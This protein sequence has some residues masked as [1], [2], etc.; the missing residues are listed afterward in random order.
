MRTGRIVAIV[1]GCVVAALGLALL[2]AGTVVTVAYGTKRDA[3]GYF[4]SHQIHLATSTSAIISDSLDL[5]DVPGD[6]NWVAE[7]GSPAAL[8]LDVRPTGSSKE[9]FVGIGPT[10]DV[11]GYLRG[12][13]HDRVSEYDDA[14]SAVA[15]ERQDGSASPALPGE[16]TFWVATLT[17]ARPGRL[18]W[19]VRGGD[20]TVVVMNADGSSGVAADA[21]VGIELEWILPVAIVL[22]VVGALLTLGGVV[23]SVMV[24]RR[25]RRGKRV[26]IVDG[27]APQLPPPDAEAAWASSSA[28][29]SDERERPPART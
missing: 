5:G 6:A 2:T 28:S 19:D 18:T 12:V 27:S 14:D 10:A 1:V 3:D 23:V 17:T 16:Q 29:P 4:R 9:L 13:S 15:Y 26:A 11:T 25:P 8:S 24:G 7:R 21:R 22:I 20:W